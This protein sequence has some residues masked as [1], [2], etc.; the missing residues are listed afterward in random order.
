MRVQMKYMPRGNEIVIERVAEGDEMR[1][2]GRNE[3]R[4]E[5]GAGGNEILN[6]GGLGDEVGNEGVDEMVAIRE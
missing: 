3:M 1:P 5:I 4:I 6:E 2:P